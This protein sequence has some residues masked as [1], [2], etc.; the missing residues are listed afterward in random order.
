MKVRADS[1]IA[2]GGAGG[3]TNGGKSSRSSREASNTAAATARE[4]KLEALAD[5]CE[6]YAFDH[7]VSS[8]QRSRFVQ[9]E[10]TK[11]DDEQRSGHLLLLG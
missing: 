1:Y 8:H 6:D 2:V 4:W 11:Y 5:L 7:C 9:I 10:L 3:T